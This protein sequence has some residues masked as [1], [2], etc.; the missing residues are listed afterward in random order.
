M[1]DYQLLQR[2]MHR[3]PGPKAFGLVV[4]GSA[5]FAV[6]IVCIQSPNGSYI[7]PPTQGQK[8]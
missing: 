8:S 5:A 1:T 2:A 4:I 7:R 3:N 6:A